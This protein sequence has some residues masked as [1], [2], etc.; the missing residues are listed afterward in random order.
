MAQDN[1]NDTIYIIIGA[2]IIIFLL[3][4]IIKFIGFI[5]ENRVVVG[6]IAIALVIVGIFVVKTQR[7]K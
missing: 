1:Q 4:L 2:A 5:V 3:W 7:N 6:L